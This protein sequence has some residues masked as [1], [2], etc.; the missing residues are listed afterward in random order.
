MT[1]FRNRNYEWERSLRAKDVE[2]ESEPSLDDADDMEGTS[3]G[4]RRVK[5]RLRRLRES[6]TEGMAFRAF[7][8]RKGRSPR[9]GELD[10]F[11]EELITSAY[12]CGYDTWDDDFLYSD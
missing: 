9:E 7:K 4:S 5:R 12:N 10:R 8:C 3:P 6:L 11:M 2:D 1:N